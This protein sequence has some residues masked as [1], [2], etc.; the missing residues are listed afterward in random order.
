MSLPRTRTIMTD[1]KQIAA[2][3]KLEINELLARAAYGYDHP[4]INM[5][6]K[7]FSENASFSLRIA[8]GDLV[9]P[10]QPR[11]AVMKLMTDSLKQQTDKRRHVISNIFY[12]TSDGYTTDSGGAIQVISNLTL[13]ATEN[14]QINIISAGVYSDTVARADG[15]WKIVKRHLDLDKAY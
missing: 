4:D 9:G 15:E 5:L 11:S 8:K 3:D 12:E 13:L 10:F 6:E 14:N 1:N 2:K 7:C